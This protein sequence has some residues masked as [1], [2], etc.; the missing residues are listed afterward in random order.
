[1]SLQSIA[2]PKKVLYALHFLNEND[3]QILI[4]FHPVK[5]KTCG[6]SKVKRKFFDQTKLK[7]D[8]T[9]IHDVTHLPLPLILPLIDF[10]LTAF[11]AVFLEAEAYG[12]RSYY[13]TEQSY[14]LKVIND[15]EVR[16]AKL[17][18]FTKFNSELINS[19]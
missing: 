7:I 5:L 12:I 11:S 1:M 8:N 16:G 3:C 6:L 10:H 18:P 9:N 15:Y 4:R 13:W 17:L 14:A 2:L 19:I